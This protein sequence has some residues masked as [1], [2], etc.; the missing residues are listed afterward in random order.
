MDFLLYLFHCI[1][2]GILGCIAGEYSTNYT[3]KDGIIG[4]V[5]LIT[6]LLFYEIVKIILI[7]VKRWDKNKAKIR[8]VISLLIVIVVFCIVC[9]IG[10]LVIKSI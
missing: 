10:E 9:I 3:L 7:K 2:E 8:A 5:T 6:T 4:A 1:V